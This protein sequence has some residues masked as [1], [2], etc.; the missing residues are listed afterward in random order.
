[1]YSTHPRYIE[2][3]PYNGLPKRAFGSISLRSKNSKPLTSDD[4]FHVRNSLLPYV[5]S[6]PV[7][8]TLP[9]GFSDKKQH[10]LLICFEGPPQVKQLIEEYLYTA[11]ELNSTYKVSFTFAD[12]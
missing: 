1:M 5:S 9:L 12:F 6:L 10:T 8:I 4:F 11:M 3:I 2:A 7:E